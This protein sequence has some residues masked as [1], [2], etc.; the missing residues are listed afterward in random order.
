[1]SEGWERRFI[2]DVDRA[3]EAVEIYS[4]LGYDVYV[5]PVL[6][7]ELGDDCSECWLVATCRFR[8]IYT[9]VKPLT[10]REGSVQNEQ[11][12]TSSET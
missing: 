2:T 12:D 9:R 1:L 4:Q 10:S 8:T 11:S 3:D 5:E 7:N 6:A